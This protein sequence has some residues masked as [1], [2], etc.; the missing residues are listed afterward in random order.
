MILQRREHWL[1]MPFLL[2]LFLINMF[3]TLLSP[4]CCQA[5]RRRPYAAEDSSHDFPYANCS[6]RVVDADVRDVLRAFADRYRLSVIMSEDVKGKI[7]I[8]V[9]NIPVKDAFESILEYAELGYMKEGDIYRIRPLSR[10]IAQEVL[11]QQVE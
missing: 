8:I 10:L 7:S 2:T 11:T 3:S 5:A 4:P 1:W 9:N 6:L